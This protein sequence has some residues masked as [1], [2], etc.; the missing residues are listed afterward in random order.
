MPPPAHCDACHTDRHLLSSQPSE[1]HY[2]QL[3]IPLNDVR[4]LVLEYA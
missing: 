3:E 2:H 4:T 1:I